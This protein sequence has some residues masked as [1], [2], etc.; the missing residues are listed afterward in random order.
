M[1]MLAL[2][3]ALALGVVTSAAVAADQIR[4]FAAA[5][6]APSLQKIADS[7]KADR[8]VEVVITPA[9]SGALAKQIEAGAPAD[10]F[11]SADLKWM[12]YVNDKGLMKDG[13]FNLLGN[14][15][16]LVAAKDDK[17]AID[18]ADKASLPAVLGQERLAVGEAKSVPAGAYAE[19]ALKSL[20][21]Y[22][23]LS[24]RFAPAENVRV[25]LQMVARGEAKLGIV[26]GT[27][28]VAEPGVAVVATFPESSHK[29]IVYPVG[30]TKGAATA[31]A[32]FLAYLKGSEANAVFG[33]AGFVKP[34]E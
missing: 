10:I 34:A 29:P 2:A 26:Y 15:L 6:V 18:F 21:L 30:L 22:D 16:V 19:E 7:Y 20:G 33:A 28:A 1:R 13:S 9:A 23:A 5:S 25:A 31:A 3:A 11:I 17:V 4:V 12:A 32:D 24:P 14:S 27:D 8:D